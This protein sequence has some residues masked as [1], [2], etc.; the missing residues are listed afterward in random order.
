MDSNHL[1]SCKYGIRTKCVTL[2]NRT[3]RTDTYKPFYKNCACSPWSAGSSHAA[4]SSPQAKCARVDG[5]W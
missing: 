5:F 4:F 2:N 3:E 1:F